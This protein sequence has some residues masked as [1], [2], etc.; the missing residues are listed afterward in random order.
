MKWAWMN[1]GPEILS[2]DA[3]CRSCMVNAMTYLLCDDMDIYTLIGFRHDKYGGIPI[4]AINCIKTEKGYQFVD[5]VQ[6]MQADEMSR[7]PPVFPEAEVSTLEEYVALILM[8]PDIKSTLDYL[9]MLEDGERFAF[10]EDRT[11]PRWFTLLYP[12]TVPLYKKGDDADDPFEHIKPE[13]IDHYGAIP[14]W[15]RLSHR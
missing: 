4:M 6:H 8:D 14:I 13:R 5:P 11:D 15:R 12:S 10:S 1:S 7:C 2:G 9:Y 3:G